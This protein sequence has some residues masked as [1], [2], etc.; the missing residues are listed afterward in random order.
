MKKKDHKTKWASFFLGYGLLQLFSLS[1][2]FFIRNSLD[3]NRYGCFN[4]YQVDDSE[5]VLRLDSERESRLKFDNCEAVV[6]DCYLFNR[7]ERLQICSFINDEWKRM[8]IPHRRSI[9]SLEAEVAFH[10]YSYKIGIDMKSAKDA[11]LGNEDDPRWYV[12]IATSAIE[13]LGL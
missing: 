2:C 13:V 12:D 5:V 9:R 8:G 11:N 6:F 3:I 10:S 7:K 4:A 1:I